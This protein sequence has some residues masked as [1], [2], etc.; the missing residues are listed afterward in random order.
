MALPNW[1]QKETERAGPSQERQWLGQRRGGTHCIID[2]GVGGFR[3]G[4]RPVAELS[5][6]N[7]AKWVGS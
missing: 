7:G 5:G 1:G 3:K 2:G 6:G 4:L